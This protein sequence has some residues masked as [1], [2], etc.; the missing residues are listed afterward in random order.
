M[1]SARMQQ[2]R[3][4]HLR[5]PPAVASKPTYVVYCCACTAEGPRFLCPCIINYK[6]T[7]VYL[8]NRDIMRHL[9]YLKLIMQVYGLF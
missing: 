2:W 9:N 1:F 6:M 5:V 8:V 4:R 3:A 7:P